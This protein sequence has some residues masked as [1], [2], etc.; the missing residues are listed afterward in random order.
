MSDLLYL[1]HI[2]K[3]VYTLLS[4]QDQRKFNKKEFNTKI[5]KNI[6]LKEFYKARGDYVNKKQLKKPA[7]AGFRLRLIDL[8]TSIGSNNRS[9][10]GDISDI[11][12]E[13]I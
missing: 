10:I 9:D 2:Y 1:V 8:D 5:E 3:R 12:T 4:K 11:E 6:F 7:V 13:E